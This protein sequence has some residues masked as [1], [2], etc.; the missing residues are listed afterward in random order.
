MYRLKLTRR[1]KQKLLSAKWLIALLAILGLGMV[2]WL[3]WIRP[4]QQA[5]EV[6]SFEACRDAGNT[7]QATYPEVCLTKDG[8]R[9]VNPVQDKAHQESQD[10]AMQPPAPIHPDLLYLDL[11]EWSVRLPL[12]T[13]TYD[14]MYSYLKD[15]LQNRITF[16]YKRLVNAGLCTGDIGLSLTRSLAE[17]QP[18]YSPTNPAPAIKV[19]DHYFYVAY[20]GSPCYDTEN[21]QQTE[22]VKQIAGDQSLTQATASLLTKLATAPAD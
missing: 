17:H 6:N 9:F 3:A 15:G 18:P 16:T 13:A 19:G 11:K 14:L 22:L 1:E 8:K 12:T 21:T 20:T 7:I 10:S 2:I 4:A 5:S